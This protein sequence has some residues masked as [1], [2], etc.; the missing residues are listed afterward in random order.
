MLSSLRERVLE[1]AAQHKATDVRVFG[2]V[3]RGQDASGSDLDL[4][5]RFAPDAD[6]FDVADL[7]AVLEDLTG[8]HVDVVSENGLRPGPNPIRDEAIAL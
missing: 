3:A 5:V 1:V 6:L 7:A 2:S 4:L 8:L